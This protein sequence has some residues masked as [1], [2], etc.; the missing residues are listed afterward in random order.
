MGRQFVDRQLWGQFAGR[1]VKVPF[2][3]RGRDYDG[4]DCWGLV[5]CCYRDVSNID[6]PMHDAY[7]TVSDHR[8]VNRLIVEGVKSWSKAVKAEAGNVACIFRRGLPL[9]CGV[10][11]PGGRRILHCEEKVGTVHEPI[12]R[13]RLEGIYEWKR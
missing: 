6:L 7:D 1:A 13:F 3:D 12:E 4:W 9:H 2:L 10:M 11:L 8:A 5:V